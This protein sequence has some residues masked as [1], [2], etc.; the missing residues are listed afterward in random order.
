MSR[1]LVTLLRSKLLQQN[2]IRWLTGG[3][4]AISENDRLIHVLL[5]LGITTDRVAKS[6]SIIEVDFVEICLS[7]EIGGNILH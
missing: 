5:P 2:P 6:F 3:E 1:L 7:R 4:H